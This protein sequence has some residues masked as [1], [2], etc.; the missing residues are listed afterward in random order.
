MATGT[1]KIC[2]WCKKEEE[3][4]YPYKSTEGWRDISVEF[5]QYNSR[6][7]NLCPD[8]LEKLG[9]VKD[10][11]PIKIRESDSYETLYDTLFE[12]ISEIIQDVIDNQ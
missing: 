10:N 5:G 9:L 7:F 1:I 6:S 12:V 4:S 2:D 11:K 3:Y 8:C